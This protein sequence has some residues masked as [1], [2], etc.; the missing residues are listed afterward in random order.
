[1][2]H[3]NGYWPVLQALLPAC[4]GAKA[5][6]AVIAG[7]AANVSQAEGQVGNTVA[8]KRAFMLKP[9]QGIDRV[10]AVLDA[11]VIQIGSRATG[12]RYLE[13]IRRRDC[14]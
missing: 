8:S 7:C 2:K 10:D 13:M 3:T 14:A 4:V 12:R 6:D 1:M 5:G 11:Q 9:G